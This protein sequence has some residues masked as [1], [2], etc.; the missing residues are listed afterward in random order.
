MRLTN[1]EKILIILLAFAG[2][3][4]LV[5]QY[6]VTPQLTAVKALEKTRAGWEQKKQDLATIDNKIQ[7]LDTELKDINTEIHTIGNGYFS[8]LEEQEE[9]IVVLNELLQVAEIS[10]KSIT[11]EPL[12]K[13]AVNAPPKG[14]SKSKDKNPKDTLTMVQNVRLAYEGNYKTLWSLLRGLWSF[15]KNIMITDLSISTISPKDTLSGLSEQLSG[16]IGLKLYDLSDI[17][18]YSGNLIQW[19]ESGS[20]RKANPFEPSIDGAFPG[21]R[22]IL[23]RGDT[24]ISQY[25]KFSDI[26]GHWA[27]SAIDNFGNKQL[28]TGDLANR[29]FPDNSITRGELVIMLDKAFKWE[30]PSDP[31][32]LTGFSDYSELGQSLSAMEKAFYKGYLNKY[33]VGY[34]DGSLKPNAPITYEEFELVMGR[35][36]KQPEFKW[37]EAA[38]AIEANAGYRSP[39]IDNKSAFMTRAEAVYFLDSLK[40]K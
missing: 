24:E 22:Y 4:Y 1:R 27:E 34:A 18:Q 3:A 38:A 8:L 11:F 30:T 20:F 14:K 12:K 10:D 33:F 23:N 31:V 21:T 9:I 6:V 2:A 37:S 17:T 25:V 26:A 40:L 19:T 15:E 32:D 35:V 36:L 13:E 16:D 29:Y 28:I 39:G 7:K 5:F